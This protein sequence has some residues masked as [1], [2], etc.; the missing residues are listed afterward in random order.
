M[1]EGA[2]GIIT[3]VG[4]DQSWDHRGVVVDW[5]VGKENCEGHFLWMLV[6][7]KNLVFNFVLEYS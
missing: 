2:F 6:E 3:R 1:D 4:L 7:K 5:G